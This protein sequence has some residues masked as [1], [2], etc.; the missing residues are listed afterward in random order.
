MAD[1][2]SW[3]RPAGGAALAVTLLDARGPTWPCVCA[4]AAAGLLRDGPAR[5]E[6]CTHAN[7][8]PLVMSQPQARPERA[9][10]RSGLCDSRR[11]R[12]EKIDP[13]GICVVA[14]GDAGASSFP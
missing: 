8:S 10:G 3:A 11:E 9:D 5:P 4:V 7:R 6:C 1:A 2:P 12:I 14:V 13:S